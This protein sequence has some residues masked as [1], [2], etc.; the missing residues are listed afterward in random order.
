MHNVIVAKFQG[1]AL[2]KFGD[3]RKLWNTAGSSNHATRSG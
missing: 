1:K 2:E 3:Q